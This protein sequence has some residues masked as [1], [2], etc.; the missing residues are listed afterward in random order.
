MSIYF[1]KVLIGFLVIFLLLFQQTKTAVDLVFLY[2][3]D[4]IV[5]IVV[6]LVWVADEFVVDSL[7]VF[8]FA[9]T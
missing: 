8:I 1:F 7:L 4:E 3:F 6:V 2:N 5:D 9:Q